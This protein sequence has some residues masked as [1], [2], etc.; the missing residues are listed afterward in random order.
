MSAL[1]TRWALRSLYWKNA[2]FQEQEPR[3]VSRDPTRQSNKDVLFVAVHE[4]AF[5]I[6]RSGSSAFRL[7][8]TAVS[9]SLLDA[10]GDG[11]PP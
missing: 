9:M 5:L 3:S 6:G 7:S 2:V 11:P 10:G 8:T 1:L 4:S